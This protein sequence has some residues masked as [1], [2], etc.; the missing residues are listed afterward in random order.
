MYN[1]GLFH[2]WVPGLVQLLLIILLTAVVL[3]IK[4]INAAN[5]GLM[6]SSTGIL[7]EYYMWGNYAVIIGFSLVLPFIWRIKTRFRSKELL[8]TTLSVMAVMSIV[9]A[10][11]TIGEIVVVACF[12]FGVA[13]MVAMVEMLL[14]IMG[15][16]SPDKE[17]KRFYAIFYPISIGSS[18]LGGFLTSSI[19]LDVGWEALHY[20]SVA[21]L[22]IVAML[23][24]IVCHNQRFEKKTPFY[25]IDWFGVTLYTTAL[26]CMA[27]IFA[28]GKQQDWFNSLEIIGAV[29]LTIASIIAL[30][31]RQLIIKR[32]FLSF[33]LYRIKDVRYGLLLLIA[34]GMFMGVGTVMS[35]YTSTI[36]GYN[37]MTNGELPLMTL[38]GIIL[39]GF[40][41]FHWAKNKIPIKMYIFS[42]FAAYFLYTVTLYFMM[43][44]E[45]N[46]AQFYLPQI[47]NGYGM[48]SL[49]IGVWIYLFDKVPQDMNVILP[50]VAPVM[51]FRSFI[52][53]A[54]FI[55]LFG[56]LH[57]EF[58]WQSVGDMAVYF[59][60]LTM[61]HNPGVG[62]LRNVQLGAILAANKRLLGYIIIAGLGVLIFVLFHQ[63]GR[64]KYRMA[65]VRAI[66]SE[67]RKQNELAERI[68][69][70]AGSI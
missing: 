56:W 33:K 17:K 69:D 61:S 11:A 24:V 58:Q 52:M 4:P 38:P 2:K 34:Q 45:L 6:S 63:F 13:N 5:I 18:Q 9:V 22:L 55:A 19:S 42:G 62:S 64:L 35:I 20:Y 48:C 31:T 65:N 23:C 30:I 60:S 66:Q 41:A 21:T 57:Y 68:A 43:V 8:I 27:Y 59:D 49:F 70:I 39:A 1:R 53:M 37:W 50:S 47:L 26:M 3:L 7:S 25:Y 32:P 12:I 67:K 54:F 29:V 36:L 16:I 40:V 14:P 44:P 15:I 28:F 10:R 51:V 46:I